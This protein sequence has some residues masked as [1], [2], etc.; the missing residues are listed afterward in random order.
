MKKIV[1]TSTFRSFGGG[2]NK[3]DRLQQLFLK[4]L[5]KQTYQNFILV[6]TIYREENVEQNVKAILGDK[7]VFVYTE[8]S[9]EYRYSPTKVVLN[10]IEYGEKNGYDILVDCSGDIILQDNMLETVAKYY[11]PM[12]TGISHP[13]IFYE[14]DDQ[15]QVLGK[16]FGSW[17]KGIDIRFFDICLLNHPDVKKRLEQY[18]LYDWGGIEHLLYGICQPYANEMINI[19]EE[20]TVIKVKN[21]REAANEDSQ[22]IQ[23]SGERNRERLK[24]LAYDIGIDFSDLLNLQ[25]IHMQYKLSKNKIRNFIHFKKEWKIWIDQ[26]LMRRGGCF[27]KLLATLIHWIL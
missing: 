10:G 3:N 5:K 13:N 25:Y 19:F 27:N 16:Y 7:A 23:R 22:Y 11:S 9:E 2:E 6:V 26:R 8:I 12:Y 24:E 20:S 14:V 1:V 17:G 21:D 4:S 15:F 18:A